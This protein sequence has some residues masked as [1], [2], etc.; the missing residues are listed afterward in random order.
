MPNQRWYKSGWEQ[1]DGRDVSLTLRCGVMDC[2]WGLDRIDQEFL[3]LDGLY[4]P[5][6]DGE[7][8]SSNE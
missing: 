1:F 2:S 4:R 3:P 5:P 6:S 7:C 8:S